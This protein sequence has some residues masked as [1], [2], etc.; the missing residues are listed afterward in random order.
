PPAA[1]SPAQWA[2]LSKAFNADRRQRYRSC[3]EFV[4]A[5]AA[6]DKATAGSIVSA[7]M[8]LPDEF[9]G[10]PPTTLAEQPLP[11]PETRNAPPPVAFTPKQILAGL[12]GMVL[13]AVAC[14]GLYYATLL[15]P[16]ESYNVPRPPTPGPVQPP[17]IQPE[18]D[19]APVWKPLRV[20]WENHPAFELW[21]SG[22]SFKNE[23]A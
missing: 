14:V 22:T 13:F 5:L 2:A 19:P 4:K 11:P 9:A 10:V 20:V 18:Q 7:A 17:V 15:P 21:F 23:G 1:L 12:A 16:H 3:V 6:A 8:P